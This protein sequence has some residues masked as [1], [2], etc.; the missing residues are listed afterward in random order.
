MNAPRRLPLIIE[1]IPIGEITHEADHFFCAN[2]HLKLA[3]GQCAKRQDQAS[4]VLGA[5]AR[6]MSGKGTLDRGKC[7]SCSTGEEVAA[8]AAAGPTRLIKANR[9]GSARIPER[10]RRLLAWAIE[11]CGLRAV[12]REV[13][14]A[15]G[16]VKRAAV[17]GQIHARSF[18]ALRNLIRESAEEA[19]QRAVA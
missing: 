17:V 12:A 4:E 13:G 6:W 19:A 3:A 15:P 9:K 10:T 16:T 1:T 11:D 5:K 2:Y 7:K 14:L 8:N 18:R